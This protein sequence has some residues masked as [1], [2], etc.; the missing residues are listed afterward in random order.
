[1]KV[2]ITPL[3]ILWC[4]A[5]LVAL[6]AFC[7]SFAWRGLTRMFPEGYRVGHTVLRVGSLVAYTAL[8]FIGGR[9]TA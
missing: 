5:T 3:A 8:V 7:E 4:A 1:M 6:W 2:T 9:V